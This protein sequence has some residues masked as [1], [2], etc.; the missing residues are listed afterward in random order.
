[1]EYG[2]KQSLPPIKNLFV[3]L[4]D[5]VGRDGRSAYLRIVLLDE[6]GDLLVHVAGPQGG[7]APA[8]KA[9]KYVNDPHVRERAVLAEDGDRSIV[10]TVPYYFKGR[11]AGQLLA[12]IDPGYV[13]DYVV[14]L[15]RAS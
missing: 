6:T 10:I 8:E 1:M 13:S 15:R 11:H 4:I 7:P 9:K 12:W 5:R 14:K 3:S 2:L